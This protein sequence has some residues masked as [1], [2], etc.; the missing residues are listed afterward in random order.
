MKKS[1][2]LGLISGISALF[3]GTV[4]PAYSLIVDTDAT[5]LAS[6]QE[7]AE[8]VI[9]VTTETFEMED[10][11]SVRKKAPTGIRFSTYVNDGYYGDLE[12]AKLENATSYHFGTLIIPKFVLGTAELTETVNN[13]LDV[14]AK[15]WGESKAEGYKVYHAVLT[16]IPNTD[17][18]TVLVARSYVCI[19][20][21]Y[22]LA[23]ETLERSIAQVASRALANN[24]SDEDGVL[25]DYVD[26]IAESVSVDQADKLMQTG[27]TAT[28]TG[29]TAP[30]GYAITWESSDK[31][32]VSV[33]DGVL[34]AVSAGEATITAK[35]GRKT[36]TCLVT[37]KDTLA[38]EYRLA[39]VGTLTLNDF[40]A[41]V[42]DEVATEDGTK[43]DGYEVTVKDENGETATYNVS[44]N[45]YQPYA[46]ANGT[47]TA[48]V[49][50][51]QTRS[52]INGSENPS[53]EYKF[54][55]NRYADYSAEGIATAFGSAENG[56]FVEY[57]ETNGVATVKN[58]GNSYG[59]IG[60]KDGISLNMARNPII[61][62][63]ITEAKGTAYFKMSYKNSNQA[64]H[65]DNG[66]VYM[67]KDTQMQAGC[68]A[69]R[70][71]TPMESEGLNAET[72]DV[73]FYVG[74]SNG[75][76][77]YL[78]LRGM[79]IVSVMEYVAPALEQLSAP[80]NIV[81][82]NGL[83]SADKV[84]APLSDG[85]TYTVEVTGDGYEE[86]LVNVSAPEVNLTNLA[87]T[88]G[89]VYNVYITANGDGLY[90]ADSETV[91]TQI[92]YNEVY[93]VSD[94]TNESISHRDGRNDLEN[95]GNG[96]KIKAPDGGNYGL[97][98]LNIDMT[99]RRLTANSLI[100]VT[101]GEIVNEC[102]YWTG[103][104]KRKSGG[105]PRDTK[106]EEIVATGETRIVSDF[107]A[108]SGSYIIDNVLYYGFGIGGH[109]GS[110][111]AITVANITIAEYAF[112]P[113]E[114]TITSG[115]LTFDKSNESALTVAYEFQNGGTLSSVSIDGKNTNDY[116]N[117][118]N[119]VT[120]NASAVSG[121]SYG[122]HTVTLTDSNGYS[123]SVELTVTNSQAVSFNAGKVEWI[124]YDVDAY[125][126][127]VFAENDLTQAVLEERTTGTS[128]TASN[129]NLN[130]IYKVVVLGLVGEET[131]EIGQITLNIENLLYWSANQ[132]INSNYH[133]NDKNDNNVYAEYDET[134][135]VAK[136]TTQHDRGWG[137]VY[138]NDFQ[139]LF[140]ENTY[141]TY[142]LG[143]VSKK[144]YVA[145]MQDDR[146]VYGSGD[147][148]GSKKELIVSI[149][150][151]GN[152]N[153]SEKKNCYIKLGSTGDNGCS[154]E[155]KSISICNITVV[156]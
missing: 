59:L 114:A 47:Y 143:E 79:Y 44:T 91:G 123:A 50:A 150:D 108:N 19:D 25:L 121:L 29:T 148:D 3:V 71:N 83:V 26:E 14:K 96:L 49:K 117:E 155:Y 1:V 36:A 13:V 55:V 67:L 84:V 95:N 139:V 88:S 137:C 76:D 31:E 102:K 68:F 149:K 56:T 57:D 64:S 120:I 9:N 154:A 156:K 118:N 20:G 127:Q 12:T 58:N 69:L 126:V 75:S 93:N 119:V 38:D 4:I 41:L 62:M 90:Y 146:Q 54:V 151:Q 147:T 124:S 53:A 15:V 2:K 81:M 136:V 133:I 94:F 27:T 134:K 48:T 61:V 37:V 43:A 142:T 39:D 131:F 52:W 112:Y 24:E 152:V 60:L 7:N 86:R 28:L 140:G 45:A 138:T 107:F 82:K 8:E 98:S 11:C 17:F 135:D 70:A 85:I 87:L 5:L 101:F 130:G 65:N 51:T 110:G 42:W 32:I 63:D 104:F 129:K 105:E 89:N 10:G 145:L 109:G 46:L 23:E 113:C 100:K 35:F 80:Q 125:K 132:L 6:A 106:F 21:V 18:D 128:W 144:Y 16:D 33:K 72:E 153:K 74:V 66:K 77:S 78:K 73:K 122:K 34:T 99:G 116:N 92:I 30:S 115:A 40:G 141:L 22:T 103:F 111:R 97:Y